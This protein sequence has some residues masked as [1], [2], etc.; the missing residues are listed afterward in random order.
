MSEISGQQSLDPQPRSTDVDGDA[1]GLTEAGAILMR[2]PKLG[3]GEVLGGGARTRRGPDGF[4]EMLKRMLSQNVIPRIV[5]KADR[6]RPVPDDS[7][8]DR[9]L[10]ITLRN[11]VAGARALCRDC[12]ARGMRPEV[13]MEK[14]LAPVA[15]SLGRSWEEDSC[16]FVTVTLG[17]RT[18]AAALDD[19]RRDSRTPMPT[20]HA[21]KV[22]LALAPGEQHSFG[23][24]IVTDAFQRAGWSVDG[25]RDASRAAL[26]GAVMRRSYDVV[27]LSVGSERHLSQLPAL[28]ME[29]RQNSKNPRVAIALGGPALILDPAAGS[30]IGADWIAIDAE[31]AVARAEAA[32]RRK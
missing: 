25:L 10:A 32:C 15:V 4:E 28:I 11:D 19:L 26:L 22:L 29:V 6:D 3:V 18:L 20:E 5:E 8:R 21:H 31:D 24:D 17:M 30:R 27:G 16:D 1:R 9:L 13:V 14:L 23:I 12:V 2:G 7:L